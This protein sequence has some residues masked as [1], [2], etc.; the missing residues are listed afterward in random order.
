MKAT[1]N[2]TRATS[3]V[4]ALGALGAC[5][6]AAVTAAPD[7]SRMVLRC[8][9][10]REAALPDGAGGVR[11]LAVGARGAGGTDEWP[12]VTG[13]SS[14]RYV[15]AGTGAGGDGTRDRPFRTIAEGVDGATEG[16]VV[17]L[18]AG[19]HTLAATVRVT[20]GVTVTGAGP[21]RTVVTLPMTETALRWEATGGTLR[22]ARLAR[23]GTPTATDAVVALDVADGASLA[24]EDVIIEGAG[25]GA[26]V[27]DAVFR[28]NRV[29]VLRAGR[30]GVRL[31]PGARAALT[32]FVVRGGAA[33]G[34]TADGAHVHLR[35]GLIDHNEGNGLALAGDVT[36]RGGSATCDGEIDL[37]GAG[38]RDCLSRVSIQCNGITG[39]YVDG[40]RVVDAREITVWGTRARGGVPSGDGVFLQGGGRM[41]LDADRPAEERVGTRSLLGDNARM[42][43][44]AEGTGTTVTARG[45][46][47]VGNA[48]GG[49][50]IQ[51][52]AVAEE[53]ASGEFRGNGGVGIGVAQDAQLRALRGTTIAATTSAEVAAVSAAGNVTLHLADGLSVAGGRVDARANHFDDNARFGAVFFMA[54]G[55]LAG[56]QGRGNLWGIR[57]WNSMVTGA[58]TERVS[59]RE[60]TPREMVGVAAGVR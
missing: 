57:A 42:G 2:T 6:E 22:G 43:I 38:P 53:V 36:T 31:R 50:F 55:E 32:G 17:A 35:D 21:D 45:L 58:E 18:S 25:I 48:N 12:N 40:A 54:T 10:D 23:G 46:R 9:G 5:E 30:N 34:V 44:L 13:A 56:N 28:A 47:A 39:I 16:T 3:W 20:A 1:M 41:M 60:E 52:S 4:A 59:G 26:Q 29:D 33:A 8:P 24:V 37:G 15:R 49:M 7:A 51:R 19:R 14:V 11:C 27:G